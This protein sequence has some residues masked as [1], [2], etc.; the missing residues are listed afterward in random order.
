MICP[1]AECFSEV[2]LQVLFCKLGGQRLHEKKFDHLVPL[3]QFYIKSR[4]R[5]SFATLADSNK[6]CKI[7]VK[8]RFNSN[9][10]QESIVSSK[11]PIGKN[12]A[13]FFTKMSHPVSL[14][15]SCDSACLHS[16]QQIVTGNTNT[17][18]T[19][20]ANIFVKRTIVTPTCTRTLKKNLIN[21]PN[22]KINV[23]KSSNTSS[24]ILTSCQK[25]VKCKVNSIS[26]PINTMQYN[27]DVGSTS[28][29]NSV[30]VTSKFQ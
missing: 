20:S 4:K 1:R 21:V 19:S 29:K 17:M 11:Q 3:I 22:S 6:K 15:Q 25:T 14:K 10:I 2:L 16:P 9:F 30:S 12:I 24:P 5:K 18:S 27:K 28:S 26:L 8:N 7:D 23:F 13:S